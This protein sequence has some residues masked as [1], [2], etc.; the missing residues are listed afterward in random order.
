[1]LG[2]LKMQKLYVRQAVAA[3]GGRRRV[4]ETFVCSHNIKCSSTALVVGWLAI[5]IVDEKFN[6]INKNDRLARRDGNEEQLNFFFFASS[7]RFPITVAIMRRPS[8]VVDDDDVFPIQPKCTQHV[9]G[10]LNAHDY[11]KNN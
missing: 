6:Q 2:I 7:L 4:E 9:P 8:I 10:V 3:S 11:V 1:M 5:S